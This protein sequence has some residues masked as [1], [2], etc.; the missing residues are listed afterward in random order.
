MV[1]HLDL[2]I[3]GTLLSWNSQSGYIEILIAIRLDWIPNSIFNLFITIFNIVP[4]RVGMEDFPDINLCWVVNWGP[5]YNVWALGLMSRTLICYKDKFTWWT[6][7]WV[8]LFA[9]WGFRF[10]TVSLNVIQ[11][12]SVRA[13]S[14]KWRG[15]CFRHSENS[16]RLILTK[17]QN[18]LNSCFFFCFK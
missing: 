11:I 3:T 12:T 10:S 17:T 13:S 18:Q 14:S 16:S 4:A 7:W 6:F 2:H 1:G 9:Y 8:L 15:H 5:R